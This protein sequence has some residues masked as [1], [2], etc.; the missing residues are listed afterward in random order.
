MTRRAAATIVIADDH[1]AA[2]AGLRVMLE[3]AGFEVCAEVGSAEAAVTAA[4]EFRPDICLL[5]I[6]VPGDGIAALAEISSRVPDSSTIV[7]TDSW[8][9]DDVFRSLKAGAAGY[10]PKDTAPDRLPQALRGV[11]AGEA[12]LPRA[13][14]ARLM[15]EFRDRGRRRS[16]L[17]DATGVRL[18]SREWEVLELMSRGLT[19][20]TMARW[21]LVSDATIRSHVASVLRKMRVPDRAAAVELY[22]RVTS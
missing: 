8:D 9:D 19:T 7:L 2:R 5:D 17:T 22:L 14:V 13:L 15:D 4:L 1:P 3:N 16:R 18:T 21:L 11:L 20:S 12:A 10:L 6:S